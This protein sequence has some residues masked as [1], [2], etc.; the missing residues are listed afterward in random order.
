MPKTIS[1]IARSHLIW[2]LTDGIGPIV[3]ARLLVHFGD[4][5]TALGISAGQLRT[6]HGIGRE[7]VER[8]AR[9]RDAARV[10]AEIEAAAEHGLR[11]ICQADP[12]Y[13]EGLKRIADPPIVLYVKGE[14][15]PTDA[16]AIAIVGTRRCTIYGSEQARR[17]GE[18]LAQAGFTIVS[19]LARGIDAFAHHGAVDADGRSIAV[20]GRGLDD[21]YP[22]DNRALAEKLLE[23]GA[24]LSEL[25][26][27]TAVRRENFPSRNR[28]IAGLT[29]GTLVVEAPQRSGALITA[30][31]ANEYNREVFAIPGRVQ[32]PTSFGSN[33]LIRDGAAKLVTCL[34][35]ILEELGEVGLAMQQKPRDADDSTDAGSESPDGQPDAPAKPAPRLSPVESRVYKVIGYEPMLQDAVLAATE[36][37]PGEILA[38]FTSLE[39]KGLIKRL[40]GQLVVRS[41]TA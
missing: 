34:D 3:F 21:V 26:V 25:P 36:L 38:A 31:L 24:W 18:L 16:L 15:L 40:P 37:P 11:I 12:D 39:L 13:P 28:I 35:D 1:N 32:D 20:F 17:F 5:E 6:V 19:G 14:L 4:A 33:A 22:P 23:H 2:A 9:S 10:A 30:R 8:I 29:L 41:G 27:R 7:T